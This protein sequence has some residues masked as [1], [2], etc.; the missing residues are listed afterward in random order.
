V[1]TMR[2]MRR[3]P[4]AWVDGIFMPRYRV[5]GDAGGGGLPIGGEAFS[6]PGRDPAHR[7]RVDP[8]EREPARG[9]WR[10][11][12]ARTAVWRRRRAR[13]DRAD[14]P[15]PAGRRKSQLRPLGIAATG[16]ALAV[17]TGCRERPVRCRRST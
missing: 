7:G 6:A 3:A 2:K 15:W 11:R 8:G 12:C 17:T 10:S 9:P 5:S 14:T 4:S 13:G 16:T 1:P